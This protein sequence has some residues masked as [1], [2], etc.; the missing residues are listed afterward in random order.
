MK[1][2]LLYYQQH[3]PQTKYIKSHTLVPQPISQH[4]I[5]TYDHVPA[6]NKGKVNTQDVTLAPPTV[7]FILTDNL[8]IT[9]SR[10]VPVSFPDYL[11][12]YFFCPKGV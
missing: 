7:S 4:G 3:D 8:M 9:H 2:I 11:F 12:I 10:S 1:K 5:R 6:L